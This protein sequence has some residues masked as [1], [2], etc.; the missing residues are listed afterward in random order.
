MITL[1]GHPFSRAHRVLWM[2][3]ELDLPF[4]HVPTGFQDGG[5]RTP[6]FR[7]I[8]PNGR[9]PALVDDG[10]AY[11]ESLAINLY[12]A[13]RYGGPLA[14]AGGTEPALA[15]QW[16]LWATTE[17]ERTLLFAAANLLLFPE[18]DR[19]ADQAAIAIEKLARP[20]GVLNYMIVERILWTWIFTIPATGAIAY[21]RER[22]LAAA[23]WNA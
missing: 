15:T 9:V 7:A 3:K 16:S 4:E 12:L 17:I 10:Q 2:L 22:V 20:F 8:N 1:Y 21:L 19:R 5:T 6:A 13:S 18:A 23:G 11:F 14:P